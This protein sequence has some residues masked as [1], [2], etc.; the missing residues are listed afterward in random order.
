MNEQTK[1][2]KR[3][4]DNIRLMIRAAV[5]HVQT[6]LSNRAMIVVRDVNDVGSISRQVRETVGNNVLD[7]HEA[8]DVRTRIEVI[9][10]GDDRAW[11]VDWSSATYLGSMGKG[12]RMVYVDRRVLADVGIV[13]DDNSDGGSDG[14]T[15][16]IE[17]D[18]HD[19]DVSEVE[20]SVAEDRRR[21]AMMINEQDEEENES[22]AN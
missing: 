6:S 22:E 7:K 9:R 2:A 17:D 8:H 18:D 11:M 14:V 16:V 4:Q 15:D 21:E 13:L 1:E 12:G 20:D 10:Q 3:Q 19:A 5:Q